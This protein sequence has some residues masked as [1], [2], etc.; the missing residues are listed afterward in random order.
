MPDEPVPSCMGIQKIPSPFITGKGPV[1]TAATYSPTVTQYRRKNRKKIPPIHISTYTV[2][3]CCQHILSTH[4]SLTHDTCR[5]KHAGMQNIRRHKGKGQLVM[6][7]FGV[8][9][10]TPASYRRRRL[11]RPS[12]KSNLAAGFV[13]RCFQHLSDPDLDTRQCAWR[14]NRQTRGRSNTVLSY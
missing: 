14:H 7:G 2:N 6:L 11:R 13:L 5:M 9:T 3:T 8:A 10:F 12:K 1:K 4:I